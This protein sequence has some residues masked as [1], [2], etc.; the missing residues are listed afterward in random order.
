MG[1]LGEHST[2]REKDKRSDRR[3]CK[4][5]LAPSGG[6]YAVIMREVNG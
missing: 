4:F 3:K 2:E 6:M 5:T 1:M